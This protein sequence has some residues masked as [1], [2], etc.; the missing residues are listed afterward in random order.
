VQASIEDA[1]ARIGTSTGRKRRRAP[2][3]IDRAA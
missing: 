1:A 2:A 3:G